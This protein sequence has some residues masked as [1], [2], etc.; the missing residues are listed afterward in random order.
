MFFSDNY[1]KIKTDAVDDLLLEKNIDFA[2]Y[3]TH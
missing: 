2:C 1:A 3:N